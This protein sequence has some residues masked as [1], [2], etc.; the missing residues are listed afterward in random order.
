MRRKVAGKNKVPGKWNEFL[1][2]ETNKK[3]FFAFLTTRVSSF[4]YPEGKEVFITSGTTV[5]GTDQHMQSPCDHEEADTRIVVHLVDALKKGQKTC[6]VRTV[7]TD[8]IV[9]LIGKF[10]HLLTLNPNA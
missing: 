8:V 1:R 2:D 7:D 9:I 10:Y 6:L 3:E 4:T 5:L